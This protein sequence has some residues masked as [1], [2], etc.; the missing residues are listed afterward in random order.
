MSTYTTTCQRLAAVL[1]A[2]AHNMHAAHGDRHLE[3]RAR[4]DLAAWLRVLGFK[5]DARPD[6][7]RIFG[8]LLF[9]DDELWQYCGAVGAVRVAH[10]IADAGEAPPKRRGD[11]ALSSACW[12]D[13]RRLTMRELRAWCRA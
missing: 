1:R 5:A 7:V 8:A 13:G 9:W 2:A 6:G 10:A 3:R 4:A 12:P 11:D